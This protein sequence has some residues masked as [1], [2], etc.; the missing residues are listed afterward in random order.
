MAE[1]AS[2]LFLDD[3]DAAAIQIQNNKRRILTKRL[4]MYILMNNNKE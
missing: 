1:H 4:F 2:S 3:I